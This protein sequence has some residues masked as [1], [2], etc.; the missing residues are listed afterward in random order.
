M[1]VQQSTASRDKEFFG[2]I[3]CEFPQEKKDTG[4]P[5]AHVLD[6]Q[7]LGQLLINH[8][9]EQHHSALQAFNKGFLTSR[10][11]QLANVQSLDKRRKQG[12]KYNLY[13]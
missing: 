10:C 2:H 7:I 8:E 13:S 3:I 4:Q 12:T 5:L 11:V 1:A 9:P 6:M